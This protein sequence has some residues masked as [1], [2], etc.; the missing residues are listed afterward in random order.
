M[1]SD[2]D[3]FASLNNLCSRLT[4]THPSVQVKKNIKNMEH[5]QMNFKE[6]RLV[7]LLFLQLHP[8]YASQAPSPPKPPLQSR[9]RPGKQEKG[10]V[11]SR[12]GR[13][14]SRWTRG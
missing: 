14:I 9:K 12:P 8:L 2:K 4:Q 3:L 11:F 10:L 6:I 7:L 5:S 1:Y 13:S